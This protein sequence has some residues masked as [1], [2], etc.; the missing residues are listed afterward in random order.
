MDKRKAHP[1]KAAVDLPPL[2]KLWA[3]CPKFWGKPVKGRLL[4][5]FTIAFAMLAFSAASAA[6]EY[7]SLVLGDGP[8]AYWATEQNQ[9]STLSDETGNA[10]NFASNRTP[11]FVNS[12]R[13]IADVVAFDGQEQYLSIN[14]SLPAFATP[15]SLELWVKFDTIS[16]RHILLQ[17]GEGDAGSVPFS[18]HLAGS[19]RTYDTGTQTAGHFAFVLNDGQQTIA[20]SDPDSAAPDQWYHLVVTYSG[21][22]LSLYRNGEVADSVSYSG[23]IAPTAQPFYMGGQPGVDGMAVEA[24]KGLAGDITLYNRAIVSSEIAEHSQEGSQPVTPDTIEITTDTS[25]TASDESYEGKQ[26][27]VDGAVLTVNGS[28]NFYSLKLINS[29]VLTHPVDAKTATGADGIDLTANHMEIDPSS[30]IKLDNKG[31]LPTDDV[32]SDSSGSY[33]G[34]AGTAEGRTTNTTYGDYK[35]PQH[36]GTGGVLTASPTKVATIGVVVVLSS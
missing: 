28:H 9:D 8:I 23:G 12:E 30:S 7:Q 31:G 13:L 1:P 14:A 32:G 5:F 34:L 16:G 33:G 17:Q 27:I 20:L 2:S 24:I 36:F 29:S 4:S 18:L 3:I 10:P 11:E 35:A 19:S 22:T 6:D 26:I 25:I 21:S 15:F